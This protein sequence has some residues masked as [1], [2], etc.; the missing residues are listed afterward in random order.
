MKAEDMPINPYLRYPILQPLTYQDVGLPQQAQVVIKAEDM[1]VG[2]DCQHHLLPW[3]YHQLGRWRVQV[4]CCQGHNVH[5][6]KPKQVPSQPEHDNTQKMIG[7]FSLSAAKATMCMPASQHMCHHNR[8]MT[9]LRQ[10]L[11]ALA[12]LLP[13]A[14]CA[15]LQV[16]TCAITTGAQQ[17]SDNDW[18]L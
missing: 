13:R 12:C 5:T 14:Q 18:L 3:S 6:C 2:G 7:C 16:N 1:P 15:C 10:R 9:T 8:S 17:H 11:V 4:A